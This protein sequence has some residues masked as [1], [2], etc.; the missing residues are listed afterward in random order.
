[1][2]RPGV[3]PFGMTK[4]FLLALTVASMFGQSKEVGLTLG[5]VFPRQ[6]NL[7]DLRP[8]LTLN[9]N[10]GQR[11][12]QNP[13]LALLGEVHLLASPLRNVE[14]RTPT[15]V[16]DFASL[17][18]MPGLR[19]KMR[20]ASRVSPYVAGGFGYAQYHASEL[21]Q[22]GNPNPF[23]DRQH[24]YGGNIGGGVDVRIHKYLSVRGEVRNFMTASPRFNTPV[25]GLQHNGQASVGIVFTK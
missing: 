18:L 5:T 12:W 13:N 17:Y 3:E 7:L 10:Y 4:I 24:T 16:R 6:R 1:M 19:L 11:V 8:G 14:S 25:A 15:A 2:L 9:A 21:L 22:N 20:P 23:R